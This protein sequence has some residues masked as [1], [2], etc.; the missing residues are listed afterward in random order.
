MVGQ[1]KAGIRLVGEPPG[2]GLNIYGDVDVVTLPASKI[3]VLVSGRLPRA[4]PGRYPPRAAAGRP[5]RGQLGGL[6]RR[7]R[8]G[9]RGGAQALTGRGRRRRWPAC[10]GSPYLATEVAGMRI[11]VTG[12]S[13][14]GGSFVVRDLREHGHDVLNVDQR[15]DGHPT[16]KTLVTD[17]TDLGQAQ[18]ALAGR[19]RRRPLRRDP[20]AGAATRGRDVSHQRAVDLQRLPGRGRP[21]H[22]ARRLGVERDG[23]RAPVRHPARLR[24][25]RRIDRPAPGVVLLA[26]EAR[27]RDDGDAV[28]P[29]Q[30]DRFRRAAHLEH[31][32]ARGLRRLPVLLGRRPHPQ[33]EPVGLRRRARRGEP[34][35]D[36][37]WRPRSRAPRWRSS[38]PPRRA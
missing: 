29:P 36:S 38:P 30:R 17:L 20:G 15:P 24:A 31:H 21:Q 22:E 9:P 12:G 18:D 16:E 6:R 5:G 26:V 34:R 14:K 8:S 7:P 4:C 23:P 35:R 10:I 19:R 1:E 13:G 2:G 37:R 32:G 25:D 11:V 33:V 3:V 28:R 27:R